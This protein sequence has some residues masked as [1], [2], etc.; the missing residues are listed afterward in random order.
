ML[1]PKKSFWGRRP[2]FDTG[3]VIHIAA[4]IGFSL[5]LGAMVL[6]WQLTPLAIVLVILSKWRTFAVQPRFWIPNIKANL[7]DMVVGVSSVGLMHQAQESNGAYVWVAVYAVWLLFIKPKSSDVWVSL[8][9]FIAQTLGLVMLFGSTDLLQHSFIVS[10]L[11]WVV[12]WSASRHY[13]SNFDEPHYKALSL[14]WGFLVLQTTWFALHWIQYYELGG[15]LIASV[16]VFLSIISVTL[17]S[18]YHAY[19]Q[20]KLTRSLAIENSVISALLLVG[21]LVSLSWH[22]TL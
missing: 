14:A 18:L 5:V 11:V 21:L 4:N 13:F 19:K 15:I 10:L 16:V 2:G 22:P 9:A 17:G 12:A 3:D 20:E 8:Q 1:Q 6:I 7:V